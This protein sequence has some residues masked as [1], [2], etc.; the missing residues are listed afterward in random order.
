[1]KFKKMTNKDADGDRRLLS[2]PVQHYTN[3]EDHHGMSNEKRWDEIIQVRVHGQ[4]H[5]L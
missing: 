1:M 2:W 5:G 3:R 4:P